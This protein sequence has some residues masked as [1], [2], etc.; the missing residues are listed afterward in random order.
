[1]DTNTPHNHRAAEALADEA[2][3]DVPEGTGWYDIAD[4][5]FGHGF[6][7]DTAYLAAIERNPW[8]T[9]HEQEAAIAKLLEEA[10]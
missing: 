7:R 5:L 9:V 4:Y 1:M 6:D 2:Y 10:R 8:L 3:M